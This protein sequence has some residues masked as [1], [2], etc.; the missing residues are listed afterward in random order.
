MPKKLTKEEVVSLAKLAQ[1]KLTDAEI[2]KYQNELNGILEYVNQLAEVDT[3]GLKPTYQVTG[4]S[5][6]LRD[7]VVVEQLASPETL[8]G[9]APASQ[10]GY[11][12]VKRMI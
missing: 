9:L 3:K 11:I 8:L 10:D 7:D 2:D 5:N 12:K 6:S 4:L 1:L